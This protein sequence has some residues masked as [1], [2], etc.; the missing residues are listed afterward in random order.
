MHLF[1]LGK[2]PLPLIILALALLIAGVV[3]VAP[4]PGGKDSLAS[5]Q[6]C[7]QATQFKCYSAYLQHKTNTVS[8]EA[9]LADLQTLYQ[10]NDDLAKRECHQLT[11]QIG[12]AAYQKY[13]S[14]PAAYRQGGSFCW[15]GYYHGVTEKAVGDMGPERIKNEANTICSS[16]AQAQR[17]SFSHYNCVH[18]LGHGF[19][20]VD[21][22]NLFKALSSCDLLADSWDRESC[23]GGV[24]MENIM[25]TTREDGHS[26]YLRPEEPMYPCTAVDTP[27]KLMCYQS[28]TS[29]VLTQMNS[30]FARVFAACQTQADAA[31]TDVCF[32]GVGRDASGSTQSDVS[33]TNAICGLAPDDNAATH[34]MLGAVRDF[35]SYFHSDKQAAELCASFKAAI[36]ERCEEEKVSYYQGF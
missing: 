34:C 23:Y 5:L 24:F 27:Y 22:F 19:M 4:W 12:H 33:R 21:S 20:A 18:G 32:E 2:I 30:D 9:A 26:D 15:S 11:H 13:G 17:Y 14:L 36:A 25:V 7:P 16:L 8:A 31:F 6:A 3:L 1:R 28:Q 35:I 10:N 29:Y